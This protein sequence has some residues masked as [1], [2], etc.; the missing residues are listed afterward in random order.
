MKHKT[1]SK[2]N[3]VLDPVISKK[4]K[5]NKSDSA[6]KLKYQPKLTAVTSEMAHSCNS[7]TFS[8]KNGVIPIVD[9]WKSDTEAIRESM[10]KLG[11]EFQ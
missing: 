8:T 3:T 4:T 6:L 2:Y 9:T 1:E 5:K 11:R 7:L 10:V